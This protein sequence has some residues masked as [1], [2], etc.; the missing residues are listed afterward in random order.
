MDIN[1]IIDFFE[2]QHQELNRKF[3]AVFLELKSLQEKIINNDETIKRLRQE[4]VSLIEELAK[5]KPKDE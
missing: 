2:Q 5:Y 3:L 4:N 1:I